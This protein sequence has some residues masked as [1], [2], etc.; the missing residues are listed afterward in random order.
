MAIDSL[1]GAAALNLLGWSATTTSGTTAGIE[2]AAVRRARAQFTTP[3]VI[4][5]WDTPAAAASTRAESVLAM[6]SLIDPASARDPDLATTFTAFKALDRLKTLAASA[7]KAGLADSSRAALDARFEKGMAEVQAF[8]AGS[9]TDK[10]RL[11]FGKSQWNMQTV[12]IPKGAATVKNPG[13]VEA[14]A[15]P[16]PAFT[17][18]E[19]FEVALTK[20]GRTDRVTASLDGKP[21]TLDNIVAALNTAIASVQL[22]RADGSVQTTPEGNPISRYISR[23]EVEKQADGKWGLTMKGVETESVALDQ[24][25]AGDSLVV[26]TGSTILDAPTASRL[27]RLDPSAGLAQKTLG[28]IEAVDREASARAALEATAKKPAAPVMAATRTAAVAVDAQ[29][30]SYVVGTTAGDMGAQLSD[31]RDRL[32]LAKVDSEGRTMWRRTLGVAGPAEGA[33]VVVTPDGGVA[34]AGSTTGKLGAGDRLSGRDSFVAKFAADGTPGFITQIDSRADDRATALAVG[35]DGSLYVGGRVDGALPGQT[36]SGGGDAFV[37]RLDSTGRVQAR[38]QFG[39]AGID[40][41]AALAV[42]TDGS[43]V[44]A[45]NGPGGASVRRVAGGDLSPVGAAATIGGAVSSLAIDRVTGAI[46][47]AGQEGGDAVVTQLD[48]SLG[49]AV[50][51]RLGGTGDDRVDSLA[52][53]DGALYAGGRTRSDLG[54]T[55]VGSGDGFVATIAANGAATAV[56]RF[57][58]PGGRTEPV[59]VAAAPGGAA[60]L[61]ALGLRRGA[62]DRP[63]SKLLIAQTTVRPGD[64]FRIRA[65]DGPVRTVTITATDTMATLATKVNRILVNE[66]KATAPSLSSGVS[67]RIEAS[68]TGR[69][70]LLAGPEGSDALARLGLAPARLQRPKASD[71]DDSLVTPGGSFGLGLDPALTLA[72]QKNAEKALARI[73]AAIGTVQ[74]ATRSLYWSDLKAQIV[75]DNA[76]GKSG[77]VPAATS[78]RIDNYR[79]ALARLTST[80][81][82]F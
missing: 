45:S 54:G 31:G 37:M 41:V 35:A 56:K 77:A 79:Q 49:G 29:G 36:G 61:G 9:S 70:E 34:V 3:A 47:A 60:A 53:M 72:D 16:I 71:G 7:A 14:R 69:V 10:L 38:T 66:G 39:T 76:F 55:A 33:S 24:V 13:V 12:A 4:A 40:S 82:G 50:A 52:W 74:S 57:G 42:D 21:P 65:G 19:I 58:T 32:F 73:E 26:A 46:A 80:T 43:V 59:M 81:G 68:K 15:T 18:T 17:G 1:S 67:L 28:T 62:I 44:I 25:G 27:I 20:A 11:A 78:A 22:V 5:P 8:L 63:E 51:T 64:S 2:T 30:F 23:F 48:A 6:K 75:N